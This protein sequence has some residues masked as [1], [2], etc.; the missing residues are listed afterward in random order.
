MTA[1]LLSCALLLSFSISAQPSSSQVTGP[2]LGLVVDPASRLRPVLGVPGASFLG[3]PISIDSSLQILA[4][5]PH[6]DY[7]LASRTDTGDTVILTNLF[8]TVVSSTLTGASGIASVV[9]SPTGSSALLES[10]DG[11]TWM[12]ATGLP[13]SPTITWQ[14][15]ISSLAQAPV[16][17]AISDNGKAVLAGAPTGNGASIYLFTSGNGPVDLMDVGQLGGVAFVTHK[18]DALVGDSSANQVQLI[19]DVTGAAT[20]GIIADATAG[21]ASP[22]DLATSED[23]NRIFIANSQP[24][25]VLLL[26]P[27]LD[28]PLN[29]SCDGTP[30]GFTR[31]APNSIFSLTSPAKGLFWIL[32]G[33]SANPRT[34]IV[35]PDPPSASDSS[36]Q[37]QAS[38]VKQ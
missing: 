8:D 17:A 21:V 24:A 19:Q 23:G 12:V 4:V 1:K 3:Q 34:V 9:L 26:D 31:L 2:V 16:V 14:T 20:S 30:T 25:G 22:V 32:E 15:D 10:S 37:T 27:Q 5:S 38:G 13:G 29:I 6:Q 33:G 7:V 18:T 36:V 11:A 28:G 35:P